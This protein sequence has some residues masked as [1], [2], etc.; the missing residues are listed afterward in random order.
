[1]NKQLYY[2]LYFLKNRILANKV[3]SAEKLEIKTRSDSY[4]QFIQKGDLVFDVG[5]N[6]GN[7]VVSLHW[8]LGL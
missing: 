4:A 7:R 1:M 5:A 3:Y 6:M 2:K 8:A